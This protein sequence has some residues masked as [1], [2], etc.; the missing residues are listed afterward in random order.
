MLERVSLILLSEI[1]DGGELKT[2]LVA[3]N[4]SNRNINGM[5]LLYSEK[6]IHLH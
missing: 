1:I 3:Q 4:S 5:E 2:S 6:E